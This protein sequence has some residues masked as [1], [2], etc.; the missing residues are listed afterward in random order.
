M[1]VVLLGLLQVIAQIAGTAASP[2]IVLI[3]KILEDAIPVLIKE[4]Q[5]V[6][7]MIKNIIT[8]LKGNGAISPEQTVQLDGLNTKVDEE[9]EAAAQAAL[10]EDAA[11]DKPA[12]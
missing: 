7:P 9:F 11:A 12:P 5:D 6:A 10:A 2:Q 4:Y 3:I 1:N 8:A